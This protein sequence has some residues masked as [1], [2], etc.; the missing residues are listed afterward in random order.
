F[1][2]GRPGTRQEFL[3]VDRCFA[4][5]HQYRA[6]DLFLARLASSVAQYSEDRQGWR[7]EEGNGGVGKFSDHHRLYT[8]G[9]A[10]RLPGDAAQDVICLPGGGSGVSGRQWLDTLPGRAVAA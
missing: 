3:T 1:G 6:G 2:L 8:R 10:R 5:W 4:S 7:G 9:F